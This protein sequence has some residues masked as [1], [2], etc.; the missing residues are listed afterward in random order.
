MKIKYDAVSH[1]GAVRANNE[2]MALVFGAFLRDDAQR[3]MVPM[4]QRPRFSALVADGMGGYG[5]GEIA[6]EMTLRSFDAF[7]TALPAGLDSDA[8]KSAVKEWFRANNEAVLAR[9]A[10]DPELARMG[11]TLTGIFTYGQYEFMINTGD[12]R[13]YRR[14]YDTLRQLS[15][16]HS[17]RERLS[18]PAVASNLIYN[19]I[20]I[21]S[22]FVDV[23]CLTEELPVIDGDT[24]LI[25][26]DGLCDM[27]PDERIDEILAAGG[28]ARALVEAAIDAGG[29]DNCTVV[30][31][32]V[33]MPVEDDVQADEPILEP[34]KKEKEEEEKP[35]VA[36]EPIEERLP[37]INPG[38]FR[39]E[40]PRRPSMP[41]E[42]PVEAA[43]GF[44]IDDDIDEHPARPSDVLPPPIPDEIRVEQHPVAESPQSDDS[45]ETRAKTAGKL[46]REAFSILFRK[47]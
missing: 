24:Y 40:A 1:V 15:V 20:G 34:D 22:A 44:S 25:C 45:I 19:A 3:S 26:S 9:A 32:H 27:I 12:S 46:V 14:R 43:I 21:P 29:R 6:S 18:D 36:E 31:L 11:T 4:K 17:E 5:G 33:S 13:V 30:L 7:I 10:T 39:A 16:D 37:E 42:V 8:V 23:T 28:N 47:K 41:V 35:P 2:D 38:M